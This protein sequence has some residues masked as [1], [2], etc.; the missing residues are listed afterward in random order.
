MLMVENDE[1][2]LGYKQNSVQRFSMNS[3]SGVNSSTLLILKPLPIRIAKISKNGI[4]RTDTLEYIT[5]L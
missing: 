5:K 2:K 3:Q 1:R 4:R